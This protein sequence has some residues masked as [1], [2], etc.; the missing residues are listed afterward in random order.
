MTPLIVSILG[1]LASFALVL[2]RRGGTHGSPT[3]PLL[4][5]GRP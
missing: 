4:R 2:A 5:E 1:S 3:G